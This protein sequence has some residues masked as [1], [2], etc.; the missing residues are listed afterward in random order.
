MLQYD[1]KSK[2]KVNAGLFFKGLSQISRGARTEG[3]H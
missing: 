1:F 2:F 3:D